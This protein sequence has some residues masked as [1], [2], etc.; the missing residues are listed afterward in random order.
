MNVID[1]E[2]GDNKIEIGNDIEGFITE[3]DI[4]ITI[5][6]SDVNKDDCLV[7]GHIYFDIDI[8]GETERVVFVFASYS[9]KVRPLVFVPMS[10]Y[11]GDE[12]SEIISKLNKILEN[13]YRG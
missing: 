1:F 4:E 9:S 10:Q 5:F 11:E 3:N 12:I 2:P 7:N 6:D 8:N 13:F